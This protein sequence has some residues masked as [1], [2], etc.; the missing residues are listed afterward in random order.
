MGPPAPADVWDF[1]ANIYSVPIDSNGTGR[2]VA[3]KFS[4]GQ[5]VAFIV[6]NENP[7]FLDAHDIPGSGFPI[8]P[9]SSFSVQAD[10][11]LKGTAS[12][13][14]QDAL[15]AQTRADLGDLSNYQGLT[16]SSKIE[17]PAVIYEREAK[18]QGIEPY[19]PIPPVKSASTIQKG[20]IRT[21][22]NVEPTIPPPPIPPAY[23][24]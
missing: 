7:L 13:A 19:A 2:V 20:E 6:V 18:A 4:P 23:S 12:M 9:T 5:K 1:G 22:V 24:R 11:V 14:S 15:A 10:L 21:F 8:L 17:D 16:A 3:D